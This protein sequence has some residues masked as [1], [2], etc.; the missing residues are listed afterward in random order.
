MLTRTF[1][2]LQRPWVPSVI[3]GA[4]LAITALAALALYSPF[5][6][7]GIVA[8]TAIATAVS[9]IAQSVI[10]RRDLGGIELRRLAESAARITIAAALLAG[11]SYGV[12]SVLDDALGR[13]TI[14]QIISLGTALLAGGAVYF[15]A[16]FAMRVPEGEQILRLVRRV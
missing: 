3:S 4:N 8:A 7:G 10:L 14:A 12:W 5:G 16:I 15:A 11:V 2:S 9:V 6:V 1:F 13:D